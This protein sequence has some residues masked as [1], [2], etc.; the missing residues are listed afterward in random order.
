LLSTKD[1]KVFQTSSFN[2]ISILPTEQYRLSFDAHDVFTIDANNNQFTTDPCQLTARLYYGAARTTLVSQAIN[3]TGTTANFVMTVPSNSAALATAVAQNAPIGVEFD[4]TSIEN[5]N[6]VAHS[7]AGVDNVVL[8][9]SGVLSGDLNGD[10]VVDINDY[11]VIRDNLQTSSLYLAKGEMTGDGKV[12]LNDFRAWTKIAGPLPGAGAGAGAGPTGSVP[13]PST[14]LLSLAGLTAI[15][16]I[17][18]RRSRLFALRCRALAAIVA[19]LFAGLLGAS[20]AQATQ[21]AYEPFNYPATSAL[22][23]TVPGPTTNGY[24][25]GNWTLGTIGTAGQTINANSLNYLGS[26][27]VGGSVNDNGLG[28]GRTGIFLA[29]DWD[30]TTTGTFYIGY[31]MNFGTT[32]GGDGGM[33]FRSE[34]FWPAGNNIQTDTGRMDIGYNQYDGSLGAA[35]QNP[36]TARLKFDVSGQTEQVVDG[37][38]ASYNQDGITHLIVLKFVLSAT[39]ASD[40]ISMYLDPTSATEPDIANASVSGVDF[41]LHAIGAG[42]NY[43]GGATGS[44][45]DELRIGTTFADVVPSFPVPGDTN[46]DGKVDLTDY[47]NIFNNF[48]LTGRTTAQGDVALSNGTQGADGKVDLGDFHLWK[49]HFPFPGSGSGAA[50]NGSVPEPSTLVLA[51]LGAIGCLARLTRK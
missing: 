38:P 49:T 32:A 13:E 23:G 46:G 5:N 24:F 25:S 30:N 42:S 22:A 21:L 20:Q 8:Q 43:G 36:A 18:I 50:S 19:A 2:A 31:E 45:F 26:P 9:I 14:L 41:T 7:W 34:E 35:E 15:A 37:S 6:L 28:G 27:S 44:T 16:G 4:T 48:N 1:G 17:H 3:L 11:R 51:L 40:S 10:G 39:A 12:D 29:H 33:G 47:N